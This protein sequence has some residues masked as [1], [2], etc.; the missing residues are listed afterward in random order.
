MEKVKMIK[1]IETEEIKKRAKKIRNE[2]NW[3]IWKVILF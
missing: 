2:K 3:W 1:E